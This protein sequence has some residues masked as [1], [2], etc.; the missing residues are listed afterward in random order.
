[1]IV[2]HCTGTTDR[3]IAQMRADGARTAD[4]VASATGA[5]LCCDS[6]RVEI[7]RILGDYSA[8]DHS[9]AGSSPA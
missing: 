5:G 6:C 3:D 1:M 2:C 4:A 8:A 7:G 9:A